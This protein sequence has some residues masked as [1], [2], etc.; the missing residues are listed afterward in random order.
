M[1]STRF[2]NLADFNKN[3]I[4]PKGATIFPKRGGAIDT[5]KKRLLAV[6]VAVDLN[7]MS[8][9]PREI[10]N[11]LLLFFFFLKTNMKKLG[12]GAT[13]RQINNYDIEP[14]V[15]NFPKEIN[16]Q[17]KLVNKLIILKNQTEKLRACYKDRQIKY[18]SFRNSILLR[19]FRG[20]LV[21]E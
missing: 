17:V 18:L 1:S 11:P 16:E 2:L 9:F 12:S 8:V 20:Q 19:A 15:I 13:I 21:K 3:S 7:I 6:D 4:I 10:L 14:L 5:N